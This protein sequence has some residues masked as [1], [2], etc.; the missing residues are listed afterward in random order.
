MSSGRREVL[1]PYREIRRSVRVS[2]RASALL[3]ACCRQ[4]I[5]E[6][7]LAS[8]LVLNA[9]TVGVP[10]PTLGQAIVLV[11]APAQ[12]NPNGKYDCSRLAAELKVTF[13]A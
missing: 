10:L 12:G 7:M 4:E 9:P 3:E 1:E 2:Y 13:T 5:E 8:G 6:T 11:A